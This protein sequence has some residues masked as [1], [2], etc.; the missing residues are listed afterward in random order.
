[1]LNLRS[2]ALFASVLFLSAA[3]PGERPRLAVKEKSSLAKVFE[4]KLELESKSITF[5]A[6]GKE[7][8][9]P[10][11]GMKVQLGDS[12]HIE[13]RDLYGALEGGRPTRLERTYAKLSGASTQHV[14]LP[15]GA[16][17]KAPDDENRERKSELEGKRV[18]FELA[19]DE[20]KTSFAGD[21]A[22]AELLEGL[23][24]DMDL[25]ALLPGKAVEEDQSWEIDAARM[26]DILNVP[27]GELKLKGEG[28]RPNASELRRD[29]HKNAT[30]KAKGTFKGTREVDG[31]KLLVIA[32][33]A[34]LETHATREDEEHHDSVEYQIEHE[35]EG[36]LLWDGEEGHFRSCELKSKISATIKD[37][38]KM[39]HGGE[40]HE[41]ERTTVFEG[42]AEFGAKIDG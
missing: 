23:D 18:V 14:D 22:D 28:D 8:E 37:T 7:V 42:E 12:E 40:S 38:R 2:S 33:E 10:A 3:L 35:L 13:V 1:M 24:E 17:G 36:E 5:K 19:D 32:L 27:G 31:H 21:K 20:Y 25:C 30:G 26:Y 39:E 16:P 6:D 41:L 29:L 11:D 4:G 9:S 15:E 34:K